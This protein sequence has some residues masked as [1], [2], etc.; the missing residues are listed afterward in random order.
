MCVYIL[1]ESFHEIMLILVTCETLIFSILIHCICHYF[2]NGIT[3]HQMN[4]TTNEPQ[5]QV[6]KHSQ[7]PS[8]V[9]QLVDAPFHT[10]KS[11]GLIPGWGPYGKQL[12]N[13]ALISMFLS[14]P[15]TFPSL[16]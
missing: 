14:L 9:A 7:S 8:L 10:P 13:V 3:N 4:L 2:K 5:T 15:P 6:E 11:R 16:L 12:I 1:K